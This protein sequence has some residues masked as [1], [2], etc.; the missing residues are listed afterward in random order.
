MNFCYGIDFLMG[1]KGKRSMFTV[2]GTKF[3]CRPKSTSLERNQLMPL[4]YEESTTFFSGIFAQV[5]S[6]EWL[7]RM[8]LLVER[9]Q[10]I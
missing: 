3:D 10:M 9:K 5:C 1:R 4:I 8:L 2:F 6:A 7:S